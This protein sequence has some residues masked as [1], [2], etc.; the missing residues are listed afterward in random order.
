MVATRSRYTQAHGTCRWLPAAA[1]G[2]VCLRISTGRVSHDYEVEEVAGG[3]HLYRID[4]KSGEVI[5][6]QIT[7]NPRFWACNCPDSQRRGWVGCKHACA[8][9]AAMDG[10]PF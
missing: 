7:V 9:K 10:L 2:N 5:C 3:Y 4:E 8:L 6:Y 1:N